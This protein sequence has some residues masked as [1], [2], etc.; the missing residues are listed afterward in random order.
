[1]FLWRNRN[2]SKLNLKLPQLVCS[3]NIIIASIRKKILR[4]A[5]CISD[6]NWCVFRNMELIDLR[7]TICFRKYEL[8]T[9]ERISVC[10]VIE[11]LRS[12]TYHQS[13]HRSVTIATM[14]SY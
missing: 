11:K 10:N 3:R 14:T 2:I 9:V 7:V 4:E 6:Q 13:H 5:A 1:M 8:V 12:M